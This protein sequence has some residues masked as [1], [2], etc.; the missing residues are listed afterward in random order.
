LKACR[1]LEE[2]E[3]HLPENWLEMA[4]QL[5]ARVSERIVPDAVAENQTV[6]A[7]KAWTAQAGFFCLGQRWSMFSL[8]ALLESPQR[9]IRRAAWLG[10]DIF[11]KDHQ[12][13]ADRLLNQVI[14]TRLQIVR[15]L[16]QPTPYARAFHQQ[17]IGWVSDDDINRFNNLIRKYI[18][19]MAAESIRLQRRRLGLETLQV[20]DVL[21]LMPEGHPVSSVGREAL[22]NACAHALQD[23][24]AVA[25]AAIRP[26]DAARFMPGIEWFDLADCA[27]ADLVLRPNMWASDRM[28]VLFNQ[29][30]PY[31]RLVQHG[32]MA[33]IG[34]C[35]RVLG[36]SAVTLTPRLAVEPFQDQAQMAL[37]GYLAELLTFNHLDAMIQDK[38]YYALLRITQ[39]VRRLVWNSLCHDYASQVYAEGAT[40]PASRELIWQQLMSIYLP[41]IEQDQA[42]HLGYGSAMGLAAPEIVWPG[43]SLADSFGLVSALL[44]WFR[45][46]GSQPQA[47]QAWLALLAP[48]RPARYFQFLERQNLPNPWD[49]VLFRQLAYHVSAFL[50]L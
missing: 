34:R 5:A 3:A 11:F 31:W 10:F 28:A 14:N 17:G 23:A 39:L 22:F 49:E 8:P 1:F 35:F 20:Y 45:G 13:E 24:S 30:H 32:T 38:P 26:N 36:Q 40:D 43:Q 48:D 42:P 7:F 18:V 33:D 29:T 46:T 9:P 25:A 6:N 2:L 47:Q 16:H 12:A 15:K 27:G 41:E 21:C 50:A 37:A 44:A 4:E 19:P